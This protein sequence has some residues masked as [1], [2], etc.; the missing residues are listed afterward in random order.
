MAEGVPETRV[1]IVDYTCNPGALGMMLLGWIVV[2]FALAHL[3]VFPLS[4]MTLVTMFFTGFGF[5]MCSYIG[6]KRGE[7]FLFYVFGSVSVFTFGFPMMTFLAKAGI[8]PAPTPDEIG[9]FFIIFALWIVALAFVTLRTPVRSESIA[10]FLAGIL[11]FIG[12]VIP[13]TGEAE[14]LNPVFGVLGMITGPLMM[15]IG[16]AMA[17]NFVAGKQVLPL[18]IRPVKK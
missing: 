3:E 5:L 12:G 16:Y 10:F 1:K 17:Y 9:Y 11:F 7:L 15:Y 18:M 14:L 4:T 8:M 6:F 13:I 2:L